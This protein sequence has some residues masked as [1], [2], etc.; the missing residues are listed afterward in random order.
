MPTTNTP[1]DFATEYATAVDFARW[2]GKAARMTAPELQFAIRDCAEARA[3]AESMGCNG[4]ASRY[5]D[6]QQTYQNESNAR[7]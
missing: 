4:N 6:E 3:C 1:T 5:A 7:D 2:A